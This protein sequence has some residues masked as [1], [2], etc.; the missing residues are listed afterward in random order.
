MS[1][2]T[3]GLLNSLDAEE[4]ELIDERLSEL[5]AELRETHSDARSLLKELVKTLDRLLHGDTKV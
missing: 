2:T 3:T 5:F 1:F 4:R